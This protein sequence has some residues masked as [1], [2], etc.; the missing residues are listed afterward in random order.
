V[1][2]DTATHL[3]SFLMKNMLIKR[4]A[5]HRNRVNGFGSKAMRRLICIAVSLYATGGFNA[6]IADDISVSGNPGSLVINSATAGFDLAPVTDAT[7]TYS[8]SVTTGTKKITGAI[9][10]AMPANTS[11]KVAL[12]APS[13][14]TSVG[15]VALSVTAQNLVTGIANGTDAIGLGISY[16]FLAAVQAGI[17][18]AASKTVTLTISD[19]L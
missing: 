16:E 7:T 13:G 12:A 17:V 2:G 14:A 9:D 3:S 8:V 19:D 10:L 4:V 18:S 15:Q 5:V 1:A 11:L 6:A